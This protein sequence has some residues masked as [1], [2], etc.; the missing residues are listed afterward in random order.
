MILVWMSPCCYLTAHVHRPNHHVLRQLNVMQDP[1][2]FKALY[3]SFATLHV[4]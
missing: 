1:R 3:L 2:V 4:S